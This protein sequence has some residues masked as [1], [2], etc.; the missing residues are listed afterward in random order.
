MAMSCSVCTTNACKIMWLIFVII[1]MLLLIYAMAEMNR[2]HQRMQSNNKHAS[3]KCL[4]GFF[5]GRNYMMRGWWRSAPQIH[6]LLRRLGAVPSHCC[7]PISR[8]SDLLYIKGE[9]YQPPNNNTD[10]VE[11]FLGDAWQMVGSST[12]KLTAVGF[13]HANKKT[14]TFNSANFSLVGSN[15]TGDNMFDRN[16]K[17]WLLFITSIVCVCQ[18]KNIINSC[19]PKGMVHA[20]VGRKLLKSNVLRVLLVVPK[21]WLE[22]YVT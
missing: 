1:G 14:S 17:S 8:N 3:W 15:A 6:F 22:A 9:E 5:N 11:C 13:D 7:W 19:L 12:N 2:T 10:T 20:W 18:F 21:M 4:L 16:K